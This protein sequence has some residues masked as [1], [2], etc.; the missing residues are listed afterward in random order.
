VDEA[1]VTSGALEALTSCL[2]ELFG[3]LCSYLEVA[4]SD[5]EVTLVAS[6]QLRSTLKI[7]GFLFRDNTADRFYSDLPDDV[8]H[9]LP[10]RQNKFLSMESFR[11][12]LNNETLFH[13]GGIITLCIDVVHDSSRSAT[14]I[15]MQLSDV[16]VQ[17]LLSQIVCLNELMLH[18]NRNL[19]VTLDSEIDFFDCADD[20]SSIEQVEDEPGVKQPTEVTPIC[21][22]L[23]VVAYLTNDMTMSFVDDANGG[24]EITLRIGDAVARFAHPRR[25]DS[26]SDTSAS[27]SFA[28]D[29][30]PCCARSKCS[31]LSFMSKSFDLCMRAGVGIPEVTLCAIVTEKSTIQACA[32]PTVEL[33]VYVPGCNH[34]VLRLSCSLQSLEVNLDASSFKGVLQMLKAVNTEVQCAPSDPHPDAHPKDALT[35][36]AD[37]SINSV[38]VRIALTSPFYPDHQ[39]ESSNRLELLGHVAP[40]DQ[41]SMMIQLKPVKGTVRAGTRPDVDVIIDSIDVH[42]IQ[43]GSVRGLRIFRMSSFYALS[44]P[45]VEVLGRLQGDSQTA[46]ETRALEPKERWCLACC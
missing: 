13:S 24:R 16:R 46:F 37:V 22:T 32:Q 14:S 5:F 27:P 30:A 29:K 26:G 11:I 9:S 8:V 18:A 12:M 23:D 1:K 33:S 4:V 41:G 7:T 6:D 15:E 3:L 25:V 35:F 40:M 38:L 21:Q 2:T 28:P 34:G 42:F 44:A 17:L 45:S 36:D 39:S 43:A 10:G 31:A 20:V 19:Q